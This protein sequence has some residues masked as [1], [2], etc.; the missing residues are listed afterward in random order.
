MYASPAALNDDLERTS[1][2]GAPTGRHK[3]SSTAMPTSGSDQRAALIAVAPF[4]PS[5]AACLTV[6]AYLRHLHAAN[7]PI[8]DAFTTFHEII[9][10]PLPAGIINLAVAWFVLWFVYRALD[11]THVSRA[12]A[13]SY[14]ALLDRLESVEARRRRLQDRL[15]SPQQVHDERSC[16]DCLLKQAAWEEINEHVRA[17][18]SELKRTGPQW[19]MG[20]GYVVLWKR[21]L[22]AEEALIQVEP[23][24]AV[25][26]GAHYDE[27]RC[28]GSAIS[29]SCDLQERVE[30]AARFLRSLQT[31]SCQAHAGRAAPVRAAEPPGPVNG[32]AA[33]VS[34]STEQV[35]GN[36]A[37]TL[38]ETSSGAHRLL[39]RLRKLLR[40]PKTL[41]ETRAVIGSSR[42][43]VEVPLD[44]VKLPRSDAEARATL[45]RVRRSINQFR[46]DRWAGLVRARNQLMMATGLTGLALY[47]AVW[48]AIMMAERFEWRDGRDP[49]EVIAY[50]AVFFLIGGTIGLFNQ[51]YRDSKAPSAV[52]DYGL[53]LA[54][55]MTTPLIS[56]LAAVCGVVL[57]LTATTGIGEFARLERFAF[58]VIAAATFGLTPTILLERLSRQAEQFKAEI[59]TSEAAESTKQAGATP[60]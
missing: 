19:V 6:V 33:I 22:T 24:E 31:M 40:G 39:R 17:I 29:Y 3:R 50:A 18:R 5:V 1:D 60:D 59:R 38:S 58:N 15:Q 53:T 10:H 37:E 12:N 32:T 21:I 8:P 4:V 42:T 46:S 25:I 11:L 51:C 56:G 23:L 13:A 35:A 55:L 34:A 26:A 54:R 49:T 9:E 7:A 44:S 52:D 45:R 30:L 2:S 36:G 20:T 14:S 27:L 57:I 47:A 16:N 48:L 43:D 41:S 28:R